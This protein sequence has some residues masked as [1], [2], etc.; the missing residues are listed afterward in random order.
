MLLAQIAERSGTALIFTAI[1]AL[2]LLLFFARILA[3]ILI[4]LYQVTIWICSMGNPV[5]SATTL[6]NL[7]I[8]L[9]L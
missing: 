5:A 2:P 8:V 3:V 4:D 9:R 1:W 6:P 7:L